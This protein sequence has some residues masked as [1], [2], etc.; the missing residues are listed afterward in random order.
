MC[1]LRKKIWNLSSYCLYYLLLRIL[2][3]FMSIYIG[4]EFNHYRCWGFAFFFFF[5]GAIKE[6]GY[7]FR[8]MRVNTSD[9][10][11]KAWSCLYEVIGLMRTTLLSHLDFYCFS[12]VWD[13]C[14]DETHPNL[15]D[16]YYMVWRRL[17]LI[18]R[19]NNICSKRKTCM[20]EFKIGRRNTS[21]QLT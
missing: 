20:D 2:E 11:N 19:G 9:L 1:N 17:L 3:F 15:N 8:V 18:F 14:V 10:F 21:G 5:R 13:L 12:F 16:L 4:K 7:G 6:V